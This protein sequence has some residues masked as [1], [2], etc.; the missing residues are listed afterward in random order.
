[1]G[2]YVAMCT[3]DRLEKLKND[4][5]EIEDFVETHL[6][7]LR[8]ILRSCV[9]RVLREQNL[10]KPDNARQNPIVVGLRGGYTYCVYSLKVLQEVSRDSAQACCLGSC[11]SLD[12]HAVSKARTCTV[13]RTSALVDLR[14]SYVPTQGGSHLCCSSCISCC[15]Y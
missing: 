14:R 8:G 13:M 6:C 1:M 7:K 11:G 2:Y 3:H 5:C 15:C 4:S 12:A 9:L 10:T